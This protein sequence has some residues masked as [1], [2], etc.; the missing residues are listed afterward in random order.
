MAANHDIIRIL[1]YDDILGDF[2]RIIG[3]AAS[4]LQ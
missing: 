3:S 2:N 1:H 4:H